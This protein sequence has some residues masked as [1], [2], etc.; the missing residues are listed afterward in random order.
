MREYCAL[1][2]CYLEQSRREDF[3]HARTATSMCG[4]RPED[5]MM[6]KTPKKPRVGPDGQ[7]QDDGPDFW[8]IAALMGAEVKAVN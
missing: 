6:F 2:D 1:A 3:W 7:T 5:I 8:T 4:G